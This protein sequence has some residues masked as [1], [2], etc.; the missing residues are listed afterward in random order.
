MH[1]PY[2]LAELERAEAR[3][4]SC[5]AVLPRRSARQRAA[6]LDP[7]LRA[8]GSAPVTGSVSPRSDEEEVDPPD[9]LLAL[10]RGTRGRET[11]AEAEAAPLAGDARR[12]TAQQERPSDTSSLR[13][14]D[15]V[16][17][18]PTVHRHR[19]ATTGP[20]ARA[21]PHAAALLGL[22]LVAAVAAWWVR[23]S[24][25]QI[26]TDTATHDLAAT[27]FAAIAS[28]LQPSIL[29][30]APS[31]EAP[32]PTAL[33]VLLSS[34]GYLVT[35]AAVLGSRCEDSAARAGAYV[36]GTGL[37]R[38]QFAA[39]VVANGRLAVL[40]LSEPRLDAA[41]LYT[42]PADVSGLSVRFLASPQEPPHLGHLL[43]R[44]RA[45][46]GMTL[47]VDPGS[48]LP[49]PGSPVWTVDGQL[50]G[51]VSAREGASGRFEVAALVELLSLLGLVQHSTRESQVRSDAGME[52]DGSIR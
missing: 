16:P 7:A 18:G 8:S 52:N 29:P 3:C 47:D 25:R 40:R 33:G 20:W 36:S 45:D 46:A 39:C 27:D 42:L 43:P 34:D 5:N 32:L 26:T 21:A 11:A 2:C 9:I 37:L 48:S 15:P 44:A 24:T 28:A 31:A 51:I 1:C 23:G 4:P 50:I 19:S 17:R 35:T 14:P 38:G 10:P 6:S 13:K 49:M 41:A 22:A 30:L 12:P